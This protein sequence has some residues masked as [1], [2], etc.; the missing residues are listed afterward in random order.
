MHLNQR[1]DHR[2][3]RGFSMFLT[4]MAMAVTA[5]FVAAAFAAAN[6]DLPQSAGSKN[7]K[8]TYA[9]AEAGLA[10]YL[11]HLQQDPDYWTKC[12]TVPDP[13]ASERSPV[14]LQWDGAGAD[15]RIWRAV[16]GGDT[17]YTVD[18]HVQD[19]RHRSAVGY[20][21]AAPQ[22]R[23]H[24]PARQLPELRLLHRVRGHRSQR[25]LGLDGTG[26]RPG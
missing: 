4:I 14:N 7:R 12:N 8:A 21:D 22:H 19:P 11:N 18:G 23:G 20:L 10:Y 24:V 6:G 2:A 1:L 13:N 3:E 16:P 17:Q 15:P 26:R 5:M 25:A 9:A